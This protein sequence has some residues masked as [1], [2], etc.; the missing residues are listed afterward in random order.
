MK[1]IVKIIT[2]IAA[3]LAAALLFTTCKQFLADPEE[4]LSYWAAEVVPESFSFN[5]AS[6]KSTDGTE[7]ITSAS[8]VTLTLNLRNPKSFSLV[9]PTSSANAGS[10]INFPGL[11]PQ[12]VLGTDYTLQQTSGSQLKLLYKKNFLEK[13]ERKDSNIGVEITLTGEDGRKFSERFSL[14]LNVNTAPSLEYKGIGKK[15]VGGEQYYVLILQAKDMDKPLPLPPPSPNY[16]HGDIK[17]LRVTKEGGTAADYEIASI[18]F[19]AK[20]F[21]WKPGSPLLDGAVPLDAD[22]LEGQ[23]Q[24]L[25]P[26][27][28]GWLIYYKTDVKVKDAAKSYTFSLIDDKGVSSDPETVSTAKVKAKDVKLY[29]KADSEITD[30]GSEAMP[31]PINTSGASV[32]LKAK[33]ETAGAK[34]TGTVKKKDGSNWTLVTN[35]N[36]NNQNNVDI[37]LP[38]PDMDQTVFYKITVKAGGKG[39]IDSAEKTFYVKV[40]KTATLTVDASKP[41]AWGKLKAAAENPTGPAEIIING[42]I[43][44]TDAADNF[45]EITITRDLTIKGKAGADTDILNA[46]RGGTNAPTEKHRIFKV[47]SGKTLTLE[48]LTLKGGYAPVSGAGGGAICAEGALTMKK[49]KVTENIAKHG[50]GGGIYAGGALT[51]T[52]CK[53]TSNTVDSD[54]LGGGGIYIHTIA[55]PTPTAVRTME[56]CTVSYNTAVKGNGGGIYVADNLTITGGSLE[57]NTVGNTSGGNGGGIYVEGS[58][59]TVKNNCNITG[60]KAI[61]NGNGGGISVAGNTTHNGVLNLFK[62]TLTGNKTEHGSGGGISVVKS[63]LTMENCTLTGNITENNATGG[64]VYVGD[65]GTFTIKDKSCITPST[66][67]DANKKGKNDVYLEDSKKINIEGVLDPDGGIAARITPASYGNNVQVLDGDITGGTPQNYKKFTVTPGGTP[68]KN[69]KVNNQGKLEKEQGGG[70]SGTTID[71]ESE[72]N[73]NTLWKKLKDAV[74]NAQAGNVITIRGAINATK[75][76]TGE[77]KNF[78]EIIIDKNITIEGTTNQTSDILNA[79]KTEGSK[80]A[81]RIFVVKN[82]AKLTLKGLTLKGGIAPSGAGGGGIFIED[83]GTVELENC[84]IEDCKTQNNGGGIYTKGTLT[85]K[86]GTIT[87]NEAKS[88]GGIYTQGTLTLDGC[89]L[90]NNKAT[91]TSGSSGGGGGVYVGSS[92]STFTMKGTS[93]IT[94]STGQDANKKGKN[95]VFLSGGSKI[96]IDGELTHTGIVARI[97][98]RSYNEST[99]VLDGAIT[100][101]TVPNQNYTKFK[102]TLK[103][104]Q[105]WSVG[106]TGYLKT[107]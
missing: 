4:F 83:G 43:T 91:T 17:R 23:P 2:P 74:K 33:T 89:T 22:D 16:L 28:D 40:T 48:N 7:C 68:Q 5:P 106:H 47:A 18:N 79:N 27:T 3:V 80:P 42:E 26:T 94:P 44:A 76:G 90:S 53:V 38:A 49:C 10:V 66:G 52:E 104:T 69:W 39:F 30:P 25:P 86:G 31:T 45:G 20:T 41:N 36:S 9:M 64:G 21:T 6:K 78:G 29:T 54:A 97:T 88:G 95:D 50:N 46:N 51:M 87:L 105:T 102:V 99:Q 13:Y 93:C 11:S 98:P 85:I 37:A 35:I 14:G 1:K 24:A 12:P 62:C 96:I 101:G 34:I 56:N 73:P 82:G 81:H 100:E 92:S 8:D 61:S 84:T 71:A 58:T 67:A 75:Y 60:N 65:S 63:H 77:H 103:G 107:P 59:L 55:P 15:T 19:S 57:N 32:T 72:T 70:S